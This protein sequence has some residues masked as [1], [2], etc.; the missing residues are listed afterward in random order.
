MTVRAK[1]KFKL[2]APIHVFAMATE[3]FNLDDLSDE[4]KAEFID[5]A[6][7]KITTSIDGI[8][9]NIY[10]IYG[11]VENP[12]IKRHHAAGIDT[13]EVELI[14]EGDVW[15]GVDSPVHIA[16]H[17]RFSRLAFTVINRLILHFKYEKANPFL[18]KANAGHLQ[19]WVWVDEGGLILHKE[20]KGNILAY[21]PGL[22]APL[23][24]TG[25]KKSDLAKLGMLLATEPEFEVVDEL[26][27]QAREAIHEEAYLLAILL[28]AVAV[29][30]KVKTS[31]LGIDSSASNAFD[32]AQEKGKVAVSPVEFISDIAKLTFNESFKKTHPTDYKNIDNLFR[33]RN[34]VAH[35]GKGVFRDEHGVFHTVDLAVLNVWWKSVATLFEWLARKLNESPL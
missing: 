29:E 22:H 34:K 27:M 17:G 4:E 9:L 10:L 19:E 12:L 24:S 14:S 6:R 18:R 11:F 16:L 32:F 21:F 31:F 33:S 8:D 1:L 30:V 13:I 3:V 35:R 26:M 5:T 2:D 25:L 20:P 28:L 15:D 7:N 23:K